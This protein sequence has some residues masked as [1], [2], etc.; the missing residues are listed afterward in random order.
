MV[1]KMRVA[2]VT[3]A[4][5]ML[6]GVAPPA[7]WAASPTT[8]TGWDS[9]GPG[10]VGAP[11]HVAASAGTTV[12]VGSNGRRGVLP[13]S[14]SGS[15]GSRIGR[16]SIPGSDAADSLA[17]GG[18]GRLLLAFGCRIMRS[19]DLGATWDDVA[20][21]GCTSGMTAGLRAFDE[22]VA[23]ASAT[24][25][26]WR[27]IDGGA[28]WDLVNG[29]ESGPSLLLDADSG[30]RIVNPAKDVLALQRTID[31][32]RSWQGLKVPNPQATAVPP[33]VDPPVEPDPV[34]PPATV[35][36]LPAMAGLARRSDGAVLVGAGS[37]LLVSGDRGESFTSVLVPVP[38]DLPGAP[39]AVIDQIVCDTA[40][41]CVV[42]VRASNDA[43]RRSALRFDDGAFGARVAALPTDDAQ[44]AGPN[45]IVGL[46]RPA[47]DASFS[48]VRTD[49][50]GASPYRVLASWQDARTAIGVHGLLAIPSAGRLHLSSDGG[51]TWSDVPD[52]AAPRLGQVAQASRGLIGLAEDGTVWLLTDGQW[53]RQADLSALRPGGMAVAGGTAFVVG[54]RGVSSLA[55]PTKPAAVSARLLQGRGF[56]SIVAKGRTI[57]AWSG[58]SAVRS[59]DGGRR[60][61]RARL[62]KGVDDVQLVSSK[63]AFALVSSSKGEV[64]H[65]STNAGASFR[66]QGKLPR[67]G[68]A[69][70][71]PEDFSA[72]AAIEFSSAT[73][74]TVVTRHGAFVT[75]DGGR[76]V[77]ALPTPGALVPVTASV[78]G[79]GVTVLDPTVGAVFRRPGLLQQPASRLTLRGASG[80]RAAKARKRA[81][82]ATV[83]GVLK[84]SGAGQRVA[85]LAVDRGGA[86]ARL[87]EV[88]ETNADGSF[89]TK[90]RL[91]RSE[92]GVQ[93][94]FAGSVAATGTERG[95][96]S[97]VLVVR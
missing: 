22:R 67:L 77:E 87:L 83:V 12:V 56:T 35:D 52:L 2:V 61:S 41:G 25:R 23:Y 24:S 29:G 37:T 58:R 85:L 96:R 70:P 9:A 15:A 72:H 82:S 93:A 80:K 8:W 60:W 27:T 33:I 19:A 20:L 40:G 43:G 7:G 66:R 84:G 88:V 78:F 81:R 32:G 16:I 69:G 21:A 91:R 50:G 54:E 79:S 31:G 39:A 46:T 86:P 65:R 94:W 3:A 48:A 45:V 95:S 4:A 26:T 51:S 73:T 47:G 34:A 64:L 10:G 18:P 5:A 6:V 74:G 13:I 28:T 92:S 59:L 53:V 36:S 76:T 49:D 63:V 1:S 89:R 11:G 42:G 55:D 90:V 62:P 97:P 44:S 68:A 57:I 14:V 71:R 75:R 17:V 38:D 30:L